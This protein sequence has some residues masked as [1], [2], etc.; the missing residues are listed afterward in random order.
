MRFA[1]F[2]NIRTITQEQM[3]GLCAVDEWR[4]FCRNY[5]KKYPPRIFGF[6]QAVILYLLRRGFIRLSSK[7]D[8][9]CTFFH[10]TPKG[11]RFFPSS[12]M[13]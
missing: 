7:K 1:H 6:K 10:L 11:R 13:Y 5:V 12:E 2:S 8:G 9:P 3:D 4:V